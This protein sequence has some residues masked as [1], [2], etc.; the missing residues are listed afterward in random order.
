MNFTQIGEY[1]FCRIVDFEQWLYYLFNGGA[2]RRV[3]FDPKEEIL[4]HRRMGTV[5]W[6]FVEDHGI[7]GMLFWGIAALVIT[8]LT[9]GRGPKAEIEKAKGGLKFREIVLWYIGFPTIIIL[10]I[11]GIFIQIGFFINGYFW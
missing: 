1:L 2:P 4:P 10:F 6:N 9:W 5:I 8:I 7:S 11:W 3:I